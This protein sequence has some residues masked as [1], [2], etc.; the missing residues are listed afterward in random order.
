MAHSEISSAM[1]VTSHFLET[2]TFVSFSVAHVTHFVFL[3]FLKIVFFHITYPD[4]GFPFTYSSSSSPSPFPSESAHFLHLIRKQTDIYR[5]KIKIKQK[6]NHILTKQRN[7]YK[8]KQ[9]TQTY[10]N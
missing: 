9:E 4:Y 1:D 2:L 7:K 8:K 6:I 3:S 10:I 5:I